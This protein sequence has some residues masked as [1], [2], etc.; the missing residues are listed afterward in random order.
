[1]PPTHAVAMGKSTRQP[2][3]SATVVSRS[4]LDTLKSL[5]Q[6][7]TAPVPS[8]TADFSRT[9]T[10]TQS[11]TS[12]AEKRRRLKELSDAR[13]S[14]WN[15][16][17]DAQRRAREEARAERLRQRE[18]ENKA[19]DDAEAVH[20]EQERMRIIDR[21]N[22]ILYQETDRVKTFNS[23]LKLASAIQ[24]HDSQN[25]ELRRRQQVEND[26]DMKYH[27]AS[28]Q[29]RLELVAKEQQAAEA[30]KQ[31]ALELAQL[32]RQQLDAHRRKLQAQHEVERQ[33]G[34]RTKKLIEL[35]IQG[36]I[37]YLTLPTHSCVC[38]LSRF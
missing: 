30:R 9:A 29:R 33:D 3:A 25:D 23:A 8:S 7:I 6:T 21:A 12:S 34:E 28:E 31:R 2:V 14:T 10:T 18:L 36:L 27:L 5:T 22:Q 15:N 19:L 1:M 38:L 17:I 16:T 37:V 35:A 26:E 24:A 32:Q 11:L 13:A 4:E 20:V